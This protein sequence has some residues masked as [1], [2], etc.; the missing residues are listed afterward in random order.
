MPKS[1]IA[2]TAAV[3]AFVAI[4]RSIH[5]MIER[6][7]SNVPV[8]MLIGRSIVEGLIWPGVLFF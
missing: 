6:W 5:L 8:N 1:T 7:D 2:I 3:Y 4:G